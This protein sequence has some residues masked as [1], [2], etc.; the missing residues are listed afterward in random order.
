MTPP[1]SH[2]GRVALVTGATSGLGLATSRAFLRLGLHVLLGARTEARG[3]SA[4]ETLCGDTAVGAPAVLVA[5][6]ATQAGVRALAHEAR[7]IVPRIDVLVCNAGV[8]RAGRH[9]TPD[10]REWTLAVNHLAPFLLTR[11]LLTHLAH[12]A[13]V[14]VVTSDAHRDVS[15]DLEDLEARQA[16]YD[17]LV[18]YRRSKLANILFARALARRAPALSV[19]AVA[20]GL[21]DTGIVREAPAAL[22]QAWAARARPADE[23]AASLVRAA[24][25]PR[26]AGP[27][28][29]YRSELRDLPP[30]REATDD[31]LADRLWD[32]SA[33]LTGTPADP[34][35]L[36]A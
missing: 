33:A 1:A 12:D 31:A 35:A 27:P 17:P 16:P 28:A 11:W 19:V 30:S 7:R 25:D 22:R 6:L 2:A 9:E 4:L 26:P 3:A 29:T 5:D 13:R 32:I 34:V 8:V 18:A 24:L 21:V 14:V 15:L 20:P 23:A 36:T 10:G